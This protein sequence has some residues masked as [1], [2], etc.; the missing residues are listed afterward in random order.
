MRVGVRVGVMRGVRV[1]A[2]VGA[3]VSVRVV[4]VS[5]AF[6]FGCVRVSAFCEGQA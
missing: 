2:K 4:R 5:G 6:G 1:G 3:R